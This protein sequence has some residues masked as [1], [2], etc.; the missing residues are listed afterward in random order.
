MVAYSFRFSAAPIKFL[1]CNKTSYKVVIEFHVYSVSIEKYE[2][3]SL[4][5]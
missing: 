1:L 4:F 2:V 5:S 3:V